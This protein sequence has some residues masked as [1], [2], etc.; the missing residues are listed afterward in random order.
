MRILKE[1]TKDKICS[2][3]LKSIDMHINDVAKQ[4]KLYAM[5][6]MKLFNKVVKLIEKNPK[7]FTIE[8]YTEIKTLVKY[9]SI[10]L[11]FHDNIDDIHCELSAFPYCQVNDD[12]ETELNHEW[13]LI[14]TLEKDG[15]FEELRG[16][17]RD[18]FERY[19]KYKAD[20]FEKIK[21]NY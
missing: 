14:L 19:T 18:F 13:N 12:P 9:K 21:N 15:K 10:C 2:K 3:V 8:K 11:K 4:Y 7:A 17:D 1:M 20:L 6:T 16:P 5:T